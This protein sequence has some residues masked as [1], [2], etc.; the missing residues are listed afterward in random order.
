MLGS[1]SKTRLTE[2]LIHDGVPR[3]SVVEVYECEPSTSYMSS[4]IVRVRVVFEKDCRW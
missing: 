3:V 1:H 4:V 2:L